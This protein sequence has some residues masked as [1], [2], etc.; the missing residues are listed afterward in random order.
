MEISWTVDEAQFFFWEF[1][2]GNENGNFLDSRRSR[3]R[4]SFFVVKKRNKTEQ[5]TTTSSKT[6]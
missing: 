1:F 6:T 3:A 5:L 4:I 2:F